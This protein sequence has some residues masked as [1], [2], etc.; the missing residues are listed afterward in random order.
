[1]IAISRIKP[2]TKSQYR[3]QYHP[4]LSFFIGKL[5]DYSDTSMYK[6]NPQSNFSSMESGKSKFPQ[7]LGISIFVIFIN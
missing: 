3:S 5:C 2:H 7:V 4:K 1:M 6:L